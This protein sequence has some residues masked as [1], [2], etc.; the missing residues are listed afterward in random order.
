M[1]LTEA[2]PH[3]RMVCRDEQYKKRAIVF[4][5]FQRYSNLLCHVDGYNIDNPGVRQL[6]NDF[7]HLFTLYTRILLSESL[8]PRLPVEKNVEFTAFDSN[9]TC[10]NCRGNI[11]NRFLTCS[12]CIGPTI[13]ERENTYDIC[14]ECYAMGKELCLHFQPEVG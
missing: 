5:S 6:I 2:L 11:F 3:A 9:I 7:Q 10:S 12:S 14:M 1:V 8:S 13:L 4:Y